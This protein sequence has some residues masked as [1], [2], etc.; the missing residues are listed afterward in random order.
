MTNER[1]IPSAK[2]PAAGT[3]PAWWFIFA[4]RKLMVF[5]EGGAVSVPL[6]V[7]PASLGL[8]P[9]RERYLGTLA[10][11]HCYC[12]EVAEH[13]PLPPEWVFTDCGISMGIL[14][15]RCLPSP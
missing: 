8:S 10:G 13:D 1:L 6:L 9:I 12:A 14:P 5:E 2:P 15:N 4:A 11:C 3:E 7:D